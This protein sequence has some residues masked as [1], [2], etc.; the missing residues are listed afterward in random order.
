[1]KTDG[2]AHFHRRPDWTGH[3]LPDSLKVRI[4]DPD[5]KRTYL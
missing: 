1:M 5:M 2:A 3:K 4:A